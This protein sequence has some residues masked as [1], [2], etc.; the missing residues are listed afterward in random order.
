MGFVS[1][2]NAVAQGHQQLEVRGIDLA[3]AELW[4]RNYCNKHPTDSVFGA[5]AAF[6]N[7]MQANAAAGR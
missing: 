2:Y 6:I 4:I 3:G 1:G 5:A 7:E